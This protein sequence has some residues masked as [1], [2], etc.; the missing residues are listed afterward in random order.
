MQGTNNNSTVQGTSRHITVNQTNVHIGKGEDR[1]AY[2]HVPKDMRL[3][4]TCGSHSE[5]PMPI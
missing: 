2:V 5:F 3:G 1:A 4:E